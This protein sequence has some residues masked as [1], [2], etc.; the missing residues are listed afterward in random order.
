MVHQPL[1]PQTQVGQA[2]VP[3]LLPLLAGA[4]DG[5]RSSEVLQGE[6]TIQAIRGRSQVLEELQS[7]AEFYADTMVLTP[8]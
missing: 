5:A 7:L 2:A 8:V 1:D 3:P 4:V 6:E